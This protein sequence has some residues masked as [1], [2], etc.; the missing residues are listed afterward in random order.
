MGS[1][2]KDVPTPQDIRVPRVF[3]GTG[4]FGWMV[5]TSSWRQ[6]I[7]RRY[8]MCYSQRVDWGNGE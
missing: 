8:G 7:G 2:R 1:V 6:G 5:V 3:R 4:L